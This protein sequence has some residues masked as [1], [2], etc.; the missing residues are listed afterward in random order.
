MCN[1]NHTPVIG[2]SM[3]NPVLAE[4]YTRLIFILTVI[5]MLLLRSYRDVHT[6]SIR[7]RPCSYISR[8]QT[9]LKLALF[10]LRIVQ[11]RYICCFCM[12]CA[13]ALKINC[14]SHQLH[15]CAKQQQGSKV[16]NF[17]CDKQGCSCCSQ[18]SLYN[19]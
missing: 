18:Q 5:L 8:F 2:L 16:A 15:H 3:F 17:V 12:F 9:F 11:G 14:N 1:H 7:R 13:I 19:T 10:M 4:F 6:S